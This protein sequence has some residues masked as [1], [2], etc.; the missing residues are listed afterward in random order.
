M[1]YILDYVRNRL[2]KK[3]ISLINKELY[4]DNIKYDSMDAIHKAFPTEGEI[5]FGDFRKNCKGENKD[6]TKVPK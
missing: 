6:K 4:I 3:R 2:A 1:I 5:F